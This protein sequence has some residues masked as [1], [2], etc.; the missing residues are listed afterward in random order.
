MVSNFPPSLT[1]LTVSIDAFDDIKPSGVLDNTHAKDKSQAALRRPRNRPSRE[2]I[3]SMSA[4]NLLSG[5]FLDENSELS[6]T[7]KVPVPR[8]RKH[9]LEKDSQPPKP[10]PSPRHLRS[11]LPLPND[12]PPKPMDTEKSPDR[13]ARA[14]KSEPRSGR[15]SPPHTR[16]P[17]PKPQLPSSIPPKPIPRR[18]R[19]TEDIQGDDIQTKDPSQLSVKERMEL[20]QKAIRKPPPVFPKKPPSGRTHADTDLFGPKSLSQPEGDESELPEMRYTSENDPSPRHVKKLP[21]GAF[22]IG[23]LGMTPYGARPRSHTVATSREHSMERENA[24]EYRELMQ[25]EAAADIDIS[26]TE[27]LETDDAEVKAPPKRPPLPL[28][29]RTSSNEK[30]NYELPNDPPPHSV[31]TEA[32]D[33]TDDG[34][35]SVLLAAEHGTLPNPSELDFDQVLTWSPAQVASWI[36][37]IGVSQYAKSFLDKGLQG[38]K[39]FDLDGGALKVVL[40]SSLVFSVVHNIYT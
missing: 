34:D 22:N 32:L 14:P 25:K 4:E 31:T 10:Q 17:S 6:P 26:S 1:F 18:N 3:R 28:T 15:M 29:K 33:E 5:P 27:P 21:P 38:N 40:I 16:A 39:L 7:E 12:R 36:N 37:R 8:P 13:K 30:P 20:A 2:H 35:S 19:R 9:T 23:L 24:E 11:P